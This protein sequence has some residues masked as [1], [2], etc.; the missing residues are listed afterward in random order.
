MKPKDSFTTEEIKKM[1]DF[2]REYIDWKSKLELRFNTVKYFTIIGEREDT[3]LGLYWN[4]T[5]IIRHVV[6]GKVTPNI[7]DREKML[8]EWV[9]RMVINYGELSQ[10]QKKRL[11]KIEDEPFLDNNIGRVKK[12]RVREYYK[13]EK[14]NLVH[15]IVLIELKGKTL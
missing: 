11:E 2:L 1:A 13:K 9:D 15:K 5:P 8:L 14:Y 6:T 10:L 3:C 7:A 4:G 12:I